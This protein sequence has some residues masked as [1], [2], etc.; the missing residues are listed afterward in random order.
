MEKYVVKKSEIE[1]MEGLAKQHFLNPNAK[2]VN[3]SLGDLTGLQNIGFH[4]IEVP[5]GYES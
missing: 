4:I 5:P 2:R 3:K 1:N